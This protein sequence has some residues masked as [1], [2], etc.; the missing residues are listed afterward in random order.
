MKFEQFIEPYGRPEHI[1]MV[2]DHTGGIFEEMRILECTFDELLHGYLTGA[3]PVTDEDPATTMLT[4]RHWGRDAISRLR[5]TVGTIENEDGRQAMARGN[6]HALNL[7]MSHMWLPLMQGGWGEHQD[8]RRH[9]IETAQDMLAQRGM[10]YYSEREYFANKQSTRE[11]N[12]FYTDGFQHYRRW[13]N[14]LVNEIDTAIVLLEVIKPFPE[15]IVI[16]APPFFEK[17]RERALNADFLLIDMDRKEVLGIQTKAT[18]DLRKGLEDK[19]DIEANNY[20]PER[21][22]VIDGSAELGNSSVRRLELTS[23]KKAVL[24]WPGLISAYRTQDLPIR[25][26]GAKR[27]EA[28]LREGMPQIESIYRDDTREVKTA[29]LVRKM[30]ARQALHGAPKSMFQDATQRIRARAIPALYR[31]PVEIT[32]AKELVHTKKSA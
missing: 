19:I 18:A 21:I 1:E 7:D 15:L 13:F 2:Q 5:E 10:H 4:Y 12:C 17:R 3:T 11:R 24:A 30:L 27:V 32:N 26:P 25:G 16:P 22:L 14:G 8:S 23:S 31:Q 28:M 6:F 20:D 29:V 9:S